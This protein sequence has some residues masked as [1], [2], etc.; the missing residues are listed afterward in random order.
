MAFVAYPLL[1]F[2][3]RQ[4]PSKYDNERGRYWMAWH[5]QSTT[6]ST[7]VVCMVLGP[8][9]RLSTYPGDAD[10]VRFASVTDAVSDSVAADM[11]RLGNAPS[12]FWCF[13]LADIVVTSLHRIGGWDNIVHHAMFILFCSIA[14]YG[15]FAAYL[16][17]VMMLMEVSTIFL[18]YFSFFR[19]RTGF[20]SESLS[21]MASFLLFALSFVA[22]RLVYFTR[23]TFEFIAASLG[24][25]IY[26]IFPDPLLVIMCVG[27]LAACGLQFYWAVIIFKKALRQAAPGLA[28]K[29]LGSGKKDDGARKAATD[30]LREPLQPN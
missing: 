5:L 11:I 14:T 25:R 10:L 19:N 4:Y 28:D 3:D 18:N 2:I 27:L 8:L 9:W 17:G 6:H 7:I 24:G 29:L 30:A 15:C 21:V 23:V 16:A 26:A 12:V 1:S 13:L 20:G 22:F